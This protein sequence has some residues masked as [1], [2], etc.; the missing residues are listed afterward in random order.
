MNE[1]KNQSTMNN[2]KETTIMNEND[3]TPTMEDTAAEETRS[4]GEAGDA[5]PHRPDKRV[6]RTPVLALVLVGILLSAAR[7][8]SCVDKKIASDETRPLPS[9][10]VVPPAVPEPDYS[11]DIQRYNAEVADAL[12]RQLRRL[13]ELAEAFETGL[14]KKGPARFDG[15]R[16]AIPGIQ[17]SF[18][19]F[20]VMAGV[21]EDGALDKAFGGDRLEA[22]FNEALDGPFIQPCTQA[23]ASLIADFETFQAQLEAETEA[24]RAELGTAHGK[25]PDAVKAD[26]PLES[27]ERGMDLS[28]AELR[29]MPFHASAT[30]AAT[31][32]E[33]ATIR[34]TV[35]AA[36]RL[37]LRFGGKAIGKAAAAVGVSAA[38]GPS[39]VLDVV[40][41]GLALWTVHDIYDLQNILPREIA[42]NLTAA[43]DGMQTQTIET[44]SNAAKQTRAAHEQAA[45]TLAASAWADQDELQVAAR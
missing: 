40:G 11:A 9:G 3:T 24:F 30:A 32:I 36:K 20:G 41:V 37:A 15:A 35:A 16:A 18:D 31:A 44:V 6:R 5:K 26:F 45:R 7:I 25:L 12:D 27:L 8:P 14:R 33:A 19:G 39:P 42:K 38:D 28:F 2:T 22:R 10:E 21:V 13:G 43:V 23:G 4:A 29:R 17:T 34:S 1:T